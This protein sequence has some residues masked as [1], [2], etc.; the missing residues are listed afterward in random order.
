MA[1]ERILVFDP[2][3]NHS[4]AVC[5]NLR[6]AGMVPAAAASVEHVLRAI[7]STPPALLLL[8]WSLPGLDGAR[9]IDGVRR[10]RIDPGLRVLIVSALASETDIVA[11]LDAGADDYLTKPY[12]SRE[13][14]ARI[15]V[16]LRGR[17]LGGVRDRLEVGALLLDSSAGRVVVGERTLRLPAVQLRL[18]AHLMTHR[19]RALR[20]AQLLATVWGQESGIDERTVDVNMRRLR[21]ALAPVGVQ[22]YI[23]TIRG[24]GYRLSTIR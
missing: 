8:E 13:L 20:R 18:L 11:G 17:R 14:V 24:I 19:D 21:R 6:A 23:Q 3:A 22:H 10:R 9:L 12:S 5:A 4:N 2:D 1:G 16:L 15:N 7:S